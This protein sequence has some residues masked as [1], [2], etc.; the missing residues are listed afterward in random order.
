M[1]YSVS[2]PQDLH[3]RLSQ[4]LSFLFLFL[5]VNKNLFRMEEDT[6][7][8]MNFS[9]KLVLLLGVNLLGVDKLV[10]LLVIFKSFAM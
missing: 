5:G 9:R 2:L 10:L 7:G 6:L 4:L 3:V 1:E 8:D